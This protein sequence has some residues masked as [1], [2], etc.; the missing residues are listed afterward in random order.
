VLGAD[1]T[2]DDAAYLRWRYRFGREGCGAGECHVL[3]LGGELL[4]LIGT[5]EVSVRWG[6]VAESGVRVMD[7]LI[8]PELSDIGLGVWL[9]LVMKARHTL[10]LAVGAN[11]NSIGL[12]KRV[13]DVLPN[14]RI[15]V[16]PIRFD[17]YMAKRVP[18]RALAWLA[19]HLAGLAMD[20][21]RAWALAFGRDGIVVTRSPELPPQADA[22]VRASEEPDRIEMAHSRAQ[23]AWRLS[24]P[25][26][27]FDIWCA[28][29][30]GELVGLMITRQ[31][32]MEDERR[33][34]TVMDVVL[35]RR[36]KPATTKALLWAVLRAAQHQQVA[37]VT[38]PSYRHD[39]EG[40]LRKAGFVEQ[41]NTYKVMAWSCQNEALRA[42]G[43]SGADWSFHEIHSDGG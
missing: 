30:Q 10:V 27:T 21:L 29:R 43:A 26:S 14:R 35:D 31:D 33:A 40:L 22:L 17:Q 5:E 25:R 39:L 16:H 12:V 11:P 28:R 2:W 9:A 24:T 34:W 37:H 4:G 20:V 41:P 1:I 6:P 38:L 23:W 18:I 13:F 8:R 42:H 7:S 3:V 36:H 19:G 32:P 15:W